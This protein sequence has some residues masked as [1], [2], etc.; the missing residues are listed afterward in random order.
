[1]TRML[2]EPLIRWHL[3]LHVATLL[4][5]IIAV[6]LPSMGP[7][8]GALMLFAGVLLYAQLVGVVRQARRA[9]RAALQP[10]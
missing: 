8:A 1:M 2:S 3:R 4:A 7:L 6:F 5:A 10:S 9:L